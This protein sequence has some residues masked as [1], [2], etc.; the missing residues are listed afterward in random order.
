MDALTGAG[1]E[2]T[3]ARAVPRAVPT[4]LVVPTGPGSGSFHSPVMRRAA[5]H[6]AA[7]HNKV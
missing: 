5:P 1:R 4:V 6:N 2:E 3:I 7:P